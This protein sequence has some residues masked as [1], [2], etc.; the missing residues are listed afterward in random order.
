MVLAGSPQF[1]MA[2]LVKI[3]VPALIILASAIVI[4]LRHAL[5]RILG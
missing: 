4:N 1:L 3:D 5:L 2:R